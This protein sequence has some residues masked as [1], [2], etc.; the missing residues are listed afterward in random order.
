MENLKVALLTFSKSLKPRI[1][2]ILILLGL[3]IT[4][5]LFG[6]LIS[7][8]SHLGFSKSILNLNLDQSQVNG[9]I[10]ASFTSPVK[11]SHKNHHHAGQS[12]QFEA[13]ETLEEDDSQ[14]DSDAVVFNNTNEYQILAPFWA[15][16]FVSFTHAPKHLQRDVLTMNCVFRI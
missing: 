11:I 16:A 4:H 7:Q 14:I 1:S 5:N 10:A 6:G 15:T 8:Q 13:I 9:S 2:M 12:I 3:A